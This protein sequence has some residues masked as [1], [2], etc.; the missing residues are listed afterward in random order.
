MRIVLDTNVL[1]AAFV[2]HGSC[3]ELVEHVFTRHEPI[4]SP[5]I[6][7]E[8]QRTLV[9]NAKVSQSEALAAVEL[10]R[11][12]CRLVEPSALVEPVCR[13]PD[14]DT[15]LGTAVAGVCACVVTGDQDLLVLEAY[16]G[17]RILRP[18]DFWRFE[19]E[20]RF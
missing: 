15:V 7:R 17:I 11:Q 8:L 13:D 10:V 3:A 5:F 14:D 9:A 19:A 1:V 18:R 6:L 2:S 12:R 20:Y 4:A 16:R